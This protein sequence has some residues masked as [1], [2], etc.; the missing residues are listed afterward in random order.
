MSLLVD[1]LESKV[2]VVTL[3][4][5]GRKA[6]FVLTWAV[7]ASLN[8]N[9]P[10][11]LLVISKFNHSARFLYPGRNLGLNL[12]SR[13]QVNEFYLFGS[14]HS[15]ELDKFAPFSHEERQGGIWLKSSAGYASLLVEQIFETPDRLIAYCEVLQEEKGSD[16]GLILNEALKLLRVDQAQAL[17]D[18]MF[19]DTKRDEI[20]FTPK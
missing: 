18:K 20:Q 9:K 17:Q 14:S 10:R 15:D 16:D 7:K 19:Q 1:D 6:G 2:F 5:Q 3:I 8:E 4:E 12:L 13:R 11:I